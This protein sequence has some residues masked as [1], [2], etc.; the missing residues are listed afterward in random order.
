MS[1]LHLNAQNIKNKINDLECLIH[2]QQSQQIKFDVICLSEHWLSGEEA[3]VFCMVGWYVGDA[4][5]RSSWKQGG[6]TILIKNQEL[7]QRWHNCWR[8]MWSIIGNSSRNAVRLNILKTFFICIYTSPSRSWDLFMS[9]MESMIDFLN[10]NVI[11]HIENCAKDD[12]AEILKNLPLS[13]SN[14]EVFSWSPKT[15]RFVMIF[16]LRICQ[17]Q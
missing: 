4:Y 10:L 6:S 9:A 11:F 12:E 8:F 13:L 7:S 15:V 14:D 16:H 5:T 3:K 1:L 2:S 17:F